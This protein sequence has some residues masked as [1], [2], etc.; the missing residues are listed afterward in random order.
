MRFLFAFA[1]LAAGGYAA[2]AARVWFGQ[3]RILFRPVRELEGTPADEG[4]GYADVE[5]A[6]R[7]GTPLHGWRVPCAGARFTLLFFH[8]NGGNVSHRLASLRLFHDLGASVLLIDYSG[9][10]RSGGRPSEG[11]L[12]ADA[13]AAWDWAAAQGSRAGDVILFGRSL[14]GAVAAGLAGE[15]AAE[16]VRPGGIILESTFT[17]AADVGARRYPWLPV[18]RLIRD[19]FDS[20]AALAG[21]HV[22]ALFAHSPTDEVVP[23][24]LGRALYEGYR[25]PKSFLPLRGGHN[26]GYLEMGQDYP[27]GLARFLSSLEG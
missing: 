2:A 11:A 21:V 27:D 25:G 5:L 6:N 7:L 22:P 4:L 19:R 17:S 18:R 15:L 26:R 23:F 20:A 3:R 9:Y 1:A 16:G 8:G 10:G 13:R 24:E 12:L 14:G